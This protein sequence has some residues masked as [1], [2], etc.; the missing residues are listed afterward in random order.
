MRNWFFIL[1]LAV[2]IIPSPGYSLA[3]TAPPPMVKEKGC[4]TCHQFS[5]D[6]SN[7]PGK[8]PRLFFAGN[9]FQSAWLREYLK[10]PVV[11]RQAGYI[12]DPGFLLGKPTVAQPHP[13]LSGE[14]AEVM[15]NYLL[16]LKIPTPAAVGM[17]KKPLSKGER[18]RAKIIFER[19][20]GCTSCHK[21]IDL[22]RKPRGGVSGP[23]LVDAGNRLQA[24]WVYRWLRNPKQFLPKGRMPVFGFEGREEDLR[25]ITQYLMTLKKENLK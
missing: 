23:S 18:A 4:D 9:K 12:T 19:N 22:A 1:L 11:I 8:A 3:Q 6:E 16:S 2:S 24:D 17:D 25:L 14:E 5:P 13:A 20:Y 7:A 21:A 10:H 15:A